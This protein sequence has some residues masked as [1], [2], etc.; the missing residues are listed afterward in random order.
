[1]GG[2]W[3]RVGE[4][5]TGR[6]HTLQVTGGG[7]DPLHC[8]HRALG[9]TTSC[10]VHNTGHQRL[11]KCLQQVQ[12]RRQLQANVGQ[13]LQDGSDDA[14]PNG[15]NMAAATTAAAS[16]TACTSESATAAATS[17]CSWPRAE[18]GV[19]AVTVPMARL[20][21][22]TSKEQFQGRLP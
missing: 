20:G 9:T 1:M 7:L 12:V 19:V 10:I 2:G 16:H 22:V 21:I 11:C 5:R 13:L 8:W 18:A 14:G 17:A 6:S 3:R 4:E 15:L